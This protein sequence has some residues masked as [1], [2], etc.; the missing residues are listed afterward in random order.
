MKKIYTLHLPTQIALLLFFAASPLHAGENEIRRSLQSKFPNIGKL[1][2]VVKTPYSGL[3]EVVIGNQ[4][5][6]TDA[7]GKYLFDGSIIDINDRH[8][9][10][11]KRRQQLF[12]IEFDKLPLELAIKKV[13]GNGKRKLAQFTD[14]NC[15]YCKRLEKE[16]N[17]VSDVTIY[18]FLYPIF[19]GSDEIVRNV[20]CAKDPVKA[21][22]D[23]MLNGIAPANAVCG[24]P[25][26]KIMA[27]GKK[28]RIGGTP[29]LIFG[30]G[31]LVPG[32]LTAEELEKRLNMPEKK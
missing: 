32:Y 5:L 17:K 24:T 20:Y 1:E 19:E 23:L 25:V 13:K 11:E 26:E 27:L 22:D 15:S 21:W 16:L 9:L 14:P 31:M 29:N 28:Y 18:S 2:H 4:L 10:T 3:Y 8:D 30:N 6:Y 7:N 12:A